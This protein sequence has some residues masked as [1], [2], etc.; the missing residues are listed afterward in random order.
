MQAGISD[1]TQIADDAGPIG[2]RAMDDGCHELCSHPICLCH[3]KPKE[4]YVIGRGGGVGRHN[5]AICFDATIF[6]H[7]A[8]A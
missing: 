1:L 7:N 8:T 3:C 6:W 2:L 4:I 5:T